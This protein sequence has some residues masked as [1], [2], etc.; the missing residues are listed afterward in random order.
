MSAK[1]TFIGGLSI[2]ILVSVVILLLIVPQFVLAQEGEP[3][4]QPDPQ[5][6]ALKESCRI[7]SGESVIQLQINIP[8]VTNSKGEVKNLAC[9]I[10]G[11]YRY[12][13]IVSGILATVMMM[14]GGFKY[15]TSFGNPNRLSDAKDNIVSAMVGLGIVLGSYLILNTINPALVDLKMPEVK[16]ISTIYQDT[17]WCEGNAVP[18]VAGATACGDKG[19]EDN[20]ECVFSGCSDASTI[21]TPLYGEYKCMNPEKYCTGTPKD[22]CDEP[23]ERL[24][25]SGIEDWVCSYS[26]RDRGDM[27]HYLD[28]LTCGEGT[29]KQVNCDIGGGSSLDSPCWDGENNQ[30]KMVLVTTGGRSAPCFNGRGGQDSRFNMLWG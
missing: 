12:F 13:A 14:F 5:T 16:S 17:N 15:V 20:A 18:E 1:K 23:D 10:A 25:K 4:S 27:C 19:K 8:G 22:S 6:Q 21:C 7:E 29:W 30:P 3:D 2:S 24:A 9:Y 11:F 26:L 28:R